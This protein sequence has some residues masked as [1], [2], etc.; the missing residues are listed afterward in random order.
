MKVIIKRLIF[1]N[2]MITKIFCAL[3]SIC[4][5]RM[6]KLILSKIKTKIYYE[7]LEWGTLVSNQIIICDVRSVFAQIK[8]V[9]GI[10]VQTPLKETPHYKIFESLVR[11]EFPEEDNIKNYK[12]HSNNINNDHDIIPYFKEIFSLVKEPPTDN[13]LIGNVVYNNKQDRFFII[14]GLHRLAAQLALDSKE[15]SL[16]LCCL[17]IDKS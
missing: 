8:D 10:L 11:K 14:D 12:I 15:V 6:N 7:L 17:T 16:R 5:F 9:D 13:F 1:N 2:K 4:S 3:S